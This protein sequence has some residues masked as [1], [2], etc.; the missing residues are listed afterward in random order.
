[1]GNWLLTVCDENTDMEY[2]EYQEKKYQEHK[3]SN[4]PKDLV[5]KNKHKANL[6]G[7]IKL[8]Y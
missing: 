5:R 7:N 1:M 8:N 3:M 2:V 4:F 6:T